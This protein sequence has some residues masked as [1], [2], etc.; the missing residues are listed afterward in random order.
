[1]AGTYVININ[2]Q[3]MI[4]TDH[5]WSY[6]SKIDE[7]SIL[8]TEMGMQR[9]TRNEGD[10]TAK[11]Y[12]AKRKLVWEV[13]DG[14]LKSKIEIQWSHISAMRAITPHNLPATL[15]IEVSFLFF[16]FLFNSLLYH[17]FTTHWLFLCS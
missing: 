5:F 6:K 13:L 7:L 10:L 15:E 2:K 14:A 11:M 12:Y 8:L 4:R 9:M 17:Y 3:N 1:M 16:S